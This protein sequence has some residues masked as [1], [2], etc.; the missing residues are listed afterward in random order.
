MK[1]IPVRNVS[2]EVQYIDNVCDTVMVQVEEDLDCACQCRP[3][4]CPGHAVVDNDTCTCT[5]AQETQNITCHVSKSFSAATCSCE[6]INLEKQCIWPLLWSASSCSCFI[7]ID[8]DLITYIIILVILVILIIQTYLN[9]KYFKQIHQ[10][11]VKYL[12]TSE[13]ILL[14]NFIWV[15]VFIFLCQDQL[16]SN[17]GGRMSLRQL[18]QQVMIQRENSGVSARLGHHAYSG[19]VN[20]NK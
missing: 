9:C 10:L 7:N 14:F 12:A 2:V 13:N 15:I 3:L 17:C 1:W 18:Q 16:D 4:S 11:Q 6:C 5:C 20:I 8:Q 19:I